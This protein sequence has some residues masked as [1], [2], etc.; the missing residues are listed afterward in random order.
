MRRILRNIEKAI[1][2]TGLAGCDV[3]MASPLLTSLRSSTRLAGLVK[4]DS[5]RWARSLAK[6]TGPQGVGFESSA[7]RV[8]RCPSGI[9][10]ARGAQWRSS[11]GS[12]STGSLRGSV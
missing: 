1:E 10:R 7:L 12:G 11:G 4:Y 9:D 3:R 2:G 6:R 5:L 8:I